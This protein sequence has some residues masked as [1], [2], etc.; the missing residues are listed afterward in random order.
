[1][2][3]MAYNM[4][5]GA[6]LSMPS[7]LLCQD[8]PCAGASL[9][10]RQGQ[11]P[12]QSTRRDLVDRRTW[13]DTFREDEDQPAGIRHRSPAAG[14]R[15][16]GRQARMG[17]SRPEGFLPSSF[18]EGGG[19]PKIS[20]AGRMSCPFSPVSRTGGP[21]TAAM[22]MPARDAFRSACIMFKNQ[23]GE[24]SFSAVLFA[25]GACAQVSMIQE[26]RFGIGV[27]TAPRSSCRTPRWTR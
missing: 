12:G 8:S 6:R 15:S 7:A 2:P 20:Q 18:P 1:M 10:P 14:A 9:M 25:V 19:N 11:P 23:T 16:G 26:R 4:A 27:V 21:Q 13:L 22:A 24:A 17:E 5:D 3:Y